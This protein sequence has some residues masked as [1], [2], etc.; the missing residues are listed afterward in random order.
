MDEGER[1]AG[2]GQ[3]ALEVHAPEA[4]H[5]GRRSKGRRQRQQAAAY[6]AQE[7]TRCGHHHGRRAACQ[8]RAGPAAQGAQAGAQAAGVGAH[9]DA[10]V[11]A[12][13]A[14]AGPAAQVAH[15]GAARGRGGGEAQAGGAAAQVGAGTGAG[16]AQV[17]EGVA[18]GAGDGRHGDGAGVA[19]DW[20]AVRQAR[21]GSATQVAHGG[22]A[23]G[24]GGAGAGGPGGVKKTC[25]NALL[26]PCQGR[27]CAGSGRHR[28]KSARASRLSVGRPASAPRVA[29][30]S[31]YIPTRHSWI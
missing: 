5:A 1:G 2:P 30:G 3:R 11:S 12:R 31:D 23:R 15:G 6:R 28:P 21:A 25:N 8:A 7:C 29:I 4:L 26:W 19:D 13:Q 24:R 14:R 16:E 9:D 17:Q 18:G 10:R 20:A 27:M 22:A